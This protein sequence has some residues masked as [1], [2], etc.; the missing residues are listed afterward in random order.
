[1]TST[2]YHGKK[3]VIPIVL[4][5]VALGLMFALLVAVL[6]HALSLCGRREVFE[7][8]Q[9]VMAE[10]LLSVGIPPDVDVYQWNVDIDRAP[11]SRSGDGMFDWVTRGAPSR[12]G[13]SVILIRLVS[14]EE[15]FSRICNNGWPMEYEFNDLSRDKLTMGGEGSNRYC[16]SPIVEQRLNRSAW[17][18]RGEYWSYVFFQKGNVLVLIYEN[19]DDLGRAGTYS[20]EAIEKLAASI[21]GR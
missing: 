1:M 9:P 5:L 2:P 13:A 16:A 8:P 17:C 11:G 3:I 18:A 15:W 10:P 12:S 6:R 21:M 20:N 7:R 4:F 14:P 19:E